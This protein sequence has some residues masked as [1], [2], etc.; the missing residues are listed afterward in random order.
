M[1]ETSLNG[2]TVL[3]RTKDTIYLRIPR[4]LQKPT[5]GCCCEFC[6][7]EKKINPN[8]IPTWDTLAIA[9]KT[10]KKGNDFAWTVHMP[11]FVSVMNALRARGEKIS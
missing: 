2:M 11:D 10:P 4:E 8:Y 6:E 1:I 3:F 7:K 5:P 9:A